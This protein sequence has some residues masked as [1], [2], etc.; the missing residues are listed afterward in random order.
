MTTKNCFTPKKI[1]L[2]VIISA[3]ALY[4][5][6]ASNYNS[7]VQ[8]WPLLL[9]LCPIMHIFMHSGHKPHHSNKSKEEDF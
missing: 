9:L 7:Y 4:L 8:F 5:L 1:F 6:S 3:V 2:I